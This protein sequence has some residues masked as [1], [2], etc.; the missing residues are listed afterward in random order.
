MLIEARKYEILYRETKINNFKGRIKK[1]EFHFFSGENL[2]QVDCQHDQR[3]RVTTI[4]SGKRKEVRT[5]KKLTDIS[6]Y[7]LNLVMPEYNL[8]FNM[9]LDIDAN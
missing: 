8:K 7:P 9:D 3:N 5:G 2:I 4:I 1:T 6:Q